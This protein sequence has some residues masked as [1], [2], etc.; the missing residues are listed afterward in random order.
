[1]YTLTLFILALIVLVGCGMPGMS[2]GSQESTS[3]SSG[4]GNSTEQEG[5]ASGE[6]Y[7]NGLPKDVE[8]T[9]KYGFFEGGNGRK[10]MGDV[11]ASFEQE[12]PNVTI[13]MLS[14]PDMSQVLSTRISAGDDEEMFDL[15]N[16][17]PSGGVVGLAEAGKL[18][19]LDDVWEKKIPDADGTVKELMMNGIYES[20]DRIEGVSYTMPTLAS[21]GGLFFNKN[22]FEEQGWNQN[23]QTWDEFTALLEQIQADGITPITF[24]GMY[25]YYHDWAFGDVE[26]YE[27]ADKNGNVDEYLE[28]YQNYTGEVFTNPANIERWEKVYELGQKGYF[29]EG[30]PA[31]SHTQSQMQVLQGD[32]AMVSTGHHVENEMKN[33]APEGF[34]WGYMSVPFIDSPDQKNWMRQGTTNGYY[35]WAAKPDLNKQ[36]AKE[37]ILWMLTL[38]AQEKAAEFGGAMPIRNDFIDDEER[39]EKLLSSSKSVLKYIDENNVQLRKAYRA[40]SITHPSYD[41]AYKLRDEA[42]SNIFLGKKDPLPVLEQMEE[43]IQEAITAQK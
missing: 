16:R 1:M 30:L 38:D 26:T 20:S 17:A 24:P 43:L 27:I 12:Y 14:S 23:P 6:V 3:G 33:S 31:L 28:D 37:F 21:V 13:D 42:I 40:V 34:K 19:P 9:L 39:Y 10:W 5:Q 35:I 22:L 11:I 8:V 7:D 36:W 29:H 15:F 25:P 18:E 2:G 32:V 41:Q 4:E